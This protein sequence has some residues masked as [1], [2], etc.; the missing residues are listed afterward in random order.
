MKRR[1][2]MMLLIALL[3]ASLAFGQT[4]PAVVRIAAKAGRMTTWGSGTYIVSDDPAKT[5]ILTCAHLFNQRLSSIEVRFPD[6]LRAMAIISAIDTKWDLAT[7]Q[8]A[9]AGDV[10]PV[11]V[12]E[13]YSRAGDPIWFA[14]HGSGSYFSQKGRAVGYVL[15]GKLSRL[16][17]RETLQLTGHARGGDSGG[18]IINERGE[19]AGVLWGSVDG[20]VYGTYCGRIQWFLGRRGNDK[21]PDG[22]CEAGKPVSVDSTPLPSGEATSPVVVLPP[23]E[24]RLDTIEDRL[25]ELLAEI[26]AIPAG[27]QGE[28]GEQGVAGEPGERGNQGEPGSV[29]LPGEP[30]VSPVIDLDELADKVAARLPG[31]SFRPI[32]FD[33]EPIGETVTKRLGETLDIYNYWIELPK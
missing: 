11:V 15:V 4:H 22:Q 2:V 29:G 24:D 12:A 27:A 6:G 1:P 20:Q 26:R 31:M 25:D 8:I 10:T 21:C 3:W 18:P 23:S 14:G 7:L 30:G 19:L 13:E 32:N 33:G 9:S 16:S 5:T 17:T 28:R